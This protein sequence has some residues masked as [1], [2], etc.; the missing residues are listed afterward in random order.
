[1]VDMR[2]A[3]KFSVRNSEEKRPFEKIRHILFIYLFMPYLTTLL[4]AQTI[5][6]RVIE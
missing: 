2:N 4:V 3:H 5:Y 6:R 1:M